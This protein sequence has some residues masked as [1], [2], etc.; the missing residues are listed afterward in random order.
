MSFY[1]LPNGITFSDLQIPDVK[2]TNESMWFKENH[3]AVIYFS[4]LGSPL[5]NLT[6][7][8]ERTKKVILSC[9]N[10]QMRNILY[11]AKDKPCKSENGK[12]MLSSQASQTGKV[13]LL[14]SRVELGKDDGALLC[15]LIN[16]K[17]QQKYFR[18]VVNV[19]GLSD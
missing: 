16:S 8:H 10:D 15:R 18:L 2:N 3:D 6:C 1:K 12:Y 7:T 14:I 9:S 11:K 19:K 4:I 17:G 5:P 13:K